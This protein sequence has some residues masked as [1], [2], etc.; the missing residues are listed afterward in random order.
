LPVERRV[1]FLAILQIVFYSVKPHLINSHPGALKER[2]FVS[3]AK[4]P[5]LYIS[6]CIGGFV[7]S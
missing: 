1:V 4:G 3:Q 5:H 2:L 7:F 6:T